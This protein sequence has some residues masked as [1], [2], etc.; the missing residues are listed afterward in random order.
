MDESS[1]DIHGS[2]F[3]I[4]FKLVG[5]LTTKHGAIKCSSIF[6][7]IKKKIVFI[8]SLIIYDFINLNPMIYFGQVFFNKFDIY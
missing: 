5:T 7:N 3:H 1:Y 2:M 6:L 4:K 8:P